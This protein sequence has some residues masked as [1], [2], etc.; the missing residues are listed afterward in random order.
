MKYQ[1]NFCF[2]EGGCGGGVSSKSLLKVWS[3]ASIC[4][5][6]TIQRHSFNHATEQQSN[7]IPHNN[8]PCLSKKK[9]FLKELQGLVNRHLL[10]R[11]LRS[12][13]DDNDS[14]EGAKDMALMLAFHKAQRRRFLF[15]SSAYRKGINRFD[16]DMEAA[17]DNDEV[18]AID[19]E[20]S[21]LPW[22]TEKEF[23]QKY[24][25]SQ[26]SFLL[27]VDALKDHPAFQSMPQGS[28]WQQAPVVNQVM[29]F[30][31]YVGAEGAGGSSSNQRQTFF[32]G[33]GTSYSYRRRV[34]CAI[35]SLRDKYYYWPDKEERKQM[36]L[37]I[38]ESFQFSHCVGVADKTLFPLCFEPQMNDA[39]D[40]SGRKYRYSLTMMIICDHCMRIR[41][42][43]SGF[44]GLAH[45]NRVWKN[46]ALK[47]CP[48]NYFGPQKYVL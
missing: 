12:I 17:E 22:L 25:M 31:K 39:P 1:T 24:W 42:Y 4:M 5:H 6:A 19:K 47:K 28:G 48:N 9:H 20:V 8:M 13:D 21:R 7:A 10:H 11:A 37:S 14:L 3:H 40:Y 45:D 26:R 27:V 29:V 18:S 38:C 2:R 43:L 36:A 15:R 46:T 30:L 33:Y 41:Y 44:P 16:V 34:T 35:M 23:L 32:I